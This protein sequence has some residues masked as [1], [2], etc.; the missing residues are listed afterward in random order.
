MGRPKFEFDIRSCEV[1]RLNRSKG[2][3]KRGHIVTDTLLT[4]QMFPRLPAVRKKCFLLCSET[5]CVRNECFPVCAARET[6]WATM[7]PQQC[8]LGYQGLKSATTTFSGLKSSRYVR[9][10]DPRFRSNE[11]PLEVNN[12]GLKTRTVDF[13]LLANS[14][15]METNFECCSF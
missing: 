6:S 9:E 12:G 8:V 13:Q 14:G 3:G 11:P 15:G 4:T 10:T 5:S 1:R 7:C 2:P